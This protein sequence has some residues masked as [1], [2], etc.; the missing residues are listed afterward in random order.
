[1]FVPDAWIAQQVQTQALARCA[2]DNPEISRRAHRP[3]RS[4]ASHRL[5]R[6]EEA[7]M[8]V[9]SIRQKIARRGRPRVLDLFAGCGGLSLGFLAGGFEIVAAVE[10]DPEAA[11]SHGRNFHGGDPIHSVPRDITK[12]SPDKLVRDLRLGRAADAFDVIIGGPPCQAF[13]RVGRSKLREIDAHP[14]AFR[15]DVRARLCVDYLTYVEACAPL[16]V[17]IENVP[18]VLNHGGQN[19][20]EEICE[21]LEDK[22][23]TCGYALSERS[24]LWRAADAHSYVSSR[25]SPPR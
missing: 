25:L 20:A 18:D 1:M 19:I 11:A 16:A 23:Y 17:L 4:A 12:T 13:A 10:N 22:N 21:V 24:V 3:D 9:R 7:G 6:C 15:H 5:R 8:N 14:E 2:R